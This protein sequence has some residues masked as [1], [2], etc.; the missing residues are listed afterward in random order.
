MLRTRIAHNRKLMKTP[1]AIA[2][3]ILAVNLAAL[4]G[5][6]IITFAQPAPNEKSDNQPAPQRRG[7]FQE[8]LQAIVPRADFAAFFR[9]LTEEQRESFRA[10]M[11]D[12]RE[13]MRGLEEKMRGARKELMNAGL[14]ERFD[15][16]AVRGKALEVGKLDAELT[17]LRAKALSKMKPA[18][19]AEQI[20]QIKN[21]PPFN[22]GEFRGENRAPSP[23]RADRPSTGP[24]DE[25]DLPA[26]PKAEK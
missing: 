7:Q 9:V 10:A 11:E 21:P 2:R 17:V 26:K 24:R 18:L 12:E 8:R 5:G 4:L 3:R 23:R 16:D 14:A 19:S 1:S 6:S 15:E 25:N 20:E 13:K 22:P